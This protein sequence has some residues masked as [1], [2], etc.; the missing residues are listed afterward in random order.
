MQES[1]IFV[2]LSRNAEV[3]N[4][5]P[6]YL[7]CGLHGKFELETQCADSTGLVH[8]LAMRQFGSYTKV[9][10][11]RIELGCRVID[12]KKKMKALKCMRLYSNKLVVFL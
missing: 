2:V 7:Q 6:F 4:K 3:K 10:S 1:M 12:P 5:L 11:I 9:V 8:F